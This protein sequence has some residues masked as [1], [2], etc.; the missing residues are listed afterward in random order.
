VYAAGVCS[1]MRSDYVSFASSRNPHLKDDKIEN[2]RVTV[3][4]FGSSHVGSF[5]DGHCV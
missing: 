2:V 1:Y 4:H 5:S 3:R